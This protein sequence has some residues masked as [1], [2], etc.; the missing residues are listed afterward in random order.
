[1]AWVGVSASEP[2]IDER[3]RLIC[4][5][6]GN[7]HAGGRAESYSQCEAWISE[8]IFGPR[9]L[10]SEVDQKQRGDEHA[11]K[12]QRHAVD[13]L[14]L[15]DKQSRQLVKRPGERGFAKEDPRDA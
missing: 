11:Q 4:S 5:E 12:F 3:I 10:E 14:P 1:M 13:G 8:E 6:Q 15:P 7:H 2:E 9:R